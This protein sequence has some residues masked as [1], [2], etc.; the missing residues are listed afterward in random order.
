ME[1]YEIEYYKNNKNE[2]IINTYHDYDGI[3]IGIRC[4][5]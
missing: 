5:F 4:M 1:I 3:I 2:K